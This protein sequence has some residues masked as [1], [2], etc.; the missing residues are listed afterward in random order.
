M[1][2]SVMLATF[3]KMS[4]TFPAQASTTFITPKKDG[5][6]RFI[7]DFWELSRDMVHKPF[8]MPKISMIYR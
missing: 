2:I 7:S 4:A 8:S 1:Q 5:T 6:A 3:G